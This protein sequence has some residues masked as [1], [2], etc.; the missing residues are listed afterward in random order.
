MITV[1]YDL[2]HEQKRED[3]YLNWSRLI[4]LSRTSWKAVSVYSSAHVNGQ[5]ESQC[6]MQ[7]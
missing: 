4:S 2:T 1:P 7:T 5:L 3:N 6:R